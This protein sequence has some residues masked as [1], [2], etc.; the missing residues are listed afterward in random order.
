MPS[1]GEN[2]AH[3]P[4]LGAQRVRAQLRATGDKQTEK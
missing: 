4:L 1:D 2:A 3:H